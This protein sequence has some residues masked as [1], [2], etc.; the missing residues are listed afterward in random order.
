[1]SFL[2]KL[3]GAAGENEC[4]AD[5]V[6]LI[7]TLFAPSSSAEHEQRKNSAEKQLKEHPM[8]AAAVIPLTKKFRQDRKGN[9]Y[10]VCTILETIGTPENSFD[11]LV[12][13]FKSGRKTKSPFDKWGNLEVES[14]GP[15]ADYAT[16]PACLLVCKIE[17]SPSRLRR[18]FRQQSMRKS[19][20][21]L[22]VGAAATA[23]S[24]HKRWRK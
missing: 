7:H 13:M 20:P 12:E 11:L 16:Q 10:N 8:R 3:F 14:F 4:P 17:N 18:V 22:I 19:L 6:N 9:E 21:E 23:L 1:M 15:N 2:K 24:W 5:V